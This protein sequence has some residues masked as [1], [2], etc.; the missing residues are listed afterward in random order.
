MRARPEPSSQAQEALGSVPCSSLHEC[1]LDGVPLSKEDSF[2]QSSLSRPLGTSGF[3]I[4]E[5]MVLSDQ[6]DL[7]VGLSSSRRASSC[8]TLAHGPG[9]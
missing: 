1:I 2:S 4:G 5:R 8:R 3:P 7:P 6:S 9:P